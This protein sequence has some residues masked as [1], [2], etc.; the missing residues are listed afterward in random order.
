M[1]KMILTLVAASALT[2]A[3]LPAAAAPYGANNIN[4]HQAQIEHRINQ[5]LRSHRLSQREAAVLRAQV[6]EV[7]RLE[8]RYRVNGLQTWERRDLDRR[9][10]RL[11]AQV[12]AQLND[13]NGH[14]GGYGGYRR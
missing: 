11:G 2:A 9:L 1:K 3:A 6:R 13:R 8:A 4:A 5:G 10:D 12:T 14:A 7:A